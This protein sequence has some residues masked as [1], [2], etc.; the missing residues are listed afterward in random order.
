MANGLFYPVGFCVVS[1]LHKG[2]C[3]AV[4]SIFCFSHLLAGM[5]VFEQEEAVF[6]AADCLKSL[7]ENCLDNAMIEQGRSALQSRGKS[8]NLVPTSVERIC[9]TASS[10]LGY[11]FSTAWDVCL[12]VVASLFDKLG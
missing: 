9:V 8:L 1:A 4:A 12:Q 6:A 7:I 3:D 2:I 11:Q 10:L 5:L